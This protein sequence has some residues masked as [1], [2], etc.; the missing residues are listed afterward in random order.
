VPVIDGRILR[1]NEEELELQ[2]EKIDAQREDN[3][4]VE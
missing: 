4:D 3:Y 1:Q 2:K